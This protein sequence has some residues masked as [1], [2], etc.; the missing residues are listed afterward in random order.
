MSPLLILLVFLLIF[1]GIYAFMTY[2]R[3]SEKRARD[4]RR[5][6]FHDRV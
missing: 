5:N 6:E 1:L 3:D 4:K 2:R